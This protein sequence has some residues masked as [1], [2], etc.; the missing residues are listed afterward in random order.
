M[1]SSNHG[2]P[3]VNLTLTFPD[4]LQCQ[5]VKP[6]GIQPVH[7]RPTIL[8][9]TH[10]RGK[11]PFAR[12]ADETRNEAVMLTIAV[13]LRKP[14]HEHAH[15]SCCDGTRCLCG[16]HAGNSGD[17]FIF[18]GRQAPRGKRPDD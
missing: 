5:P 11:A 2:P 7:C 18:F 8:P 6:G 3:I 16:S 14:H 10:I 13:Y 4:P 17:R 9:L 15:S 12:D 1:Q